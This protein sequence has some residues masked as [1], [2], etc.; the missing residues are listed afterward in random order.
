MR[1]TFIDFLSKKVA[2]DQRIKL[3][4]G[5]L[6]FSLFE[7]FCA[8][9]PQHFINTGI[10][11]SLMVGVAS[12]LARL[13]H[14]PYV[15]SIA[16]FLY[17]RALEQ[18]KL[19]VDWANLNVKFIGAGAGVGYAQAGTSHYS[20]EDMAIM[21]T[22]PN[23]RVYSPADTTEVGQCLEEMHAHQGPCYLRLAHHSHTLF[24]P[25]EDNDYVPFKEILKGEGT[26][27]V[28]TGPRLP[29]WCENLSI[30]SDARLGLYHIS[31]IA[32]F[33]DEEAL[34]YL[35]DYEELLVIQDQYAHLGLFHELSR[36]SALHKLSFLLHPL[37][38]SP[39][40]P[41]RFGDAEFMRQLHHSSD[42]KI[43]TALKK[44]FFHETVS[45]DS[46]L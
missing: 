4:T 13:G 31:R 38:L 37:G 36:L 44:R 23:M 35:K 28:C 42:E 15:Y 9:Y 6:G 3:L 5:D 21:S 1:K 14:I 41:E 8:R 45:S 34:L 46:L 17:L 2:S 12:G 43:L 33:P 11:E 29:F 26:A 25:D 18:I 39:T 10:A 22:L 16:P 24:T 30:L 27:L 32:P 20:L 19:D 7:D 40:Y